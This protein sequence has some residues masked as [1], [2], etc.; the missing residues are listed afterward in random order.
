VGRDGV[1]VDLTEQESAERIFISREHC[2]IHVQKG[3][4]FLEDNNSTNG[5]FLNRTRLQPGEKIQLK[6]DDL[7]Q[8]G[9]ITLKVRM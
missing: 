3:K 4:V 6:T 9:P 1:E 2:F 8:I 7:I 5:T